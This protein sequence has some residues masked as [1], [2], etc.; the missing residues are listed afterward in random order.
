[1]RGTTVDPG[2]IAAVA[3]GLAAVD[4]F[5]LERDGVLARLREARR[6]RGFADTCEAALA[7]RLDALTAVGADDRREHVSSAADEAA[8][9]D[10]L[11]G[12]DHGLP[13]ESERDRQRTRRRGALLDRCPGFA[14]RWKPARSPSATSTS[15]PPRSPPSNRPSPS[16]CSPTKT[17]SSTSPAGPP[18][19]PS[20]PASVN[21]S[22]SSAPTAG[23]PASNA[24][25]ATATLTAPPIPT[26]GMYRLF[27]ELDPERGT[28]IS[29]AIQPAWTASTRP[30]APPTGSPRNRSAPKRSSS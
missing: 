30:P 17:P 2:E 6:L 7:R 18:P 27:A 3:S 19:R 26:P 16:N 21:A 11:F 12:P 10:S 1:M 23:C 15:S 4:E 8:E 28:A 14:R 22:T 13:R 5:V 20:L 9:S 29:Q 25:A 24:N